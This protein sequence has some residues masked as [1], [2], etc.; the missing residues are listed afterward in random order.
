MS[1]LALLAIASLLS[2]FTVVDSRP[3]AAA[4]ISAEVAAFDRNTGEGN[5][6][7]TTELSK[8]LVVSFSKSGALSS[9]S[10]QGSAVASFGVLSTLG[11]ATASTVI[12]DPA[13]RPN[14]PNPASARGFGTAHF[15]DRITVHATSGDVLVRVSAV[16]HAQ[17]DSLGY[18]LD[19][20]CSPG[21]IGDFGNTEPFVL[22]HL[23]GF[24]IINQ[25]LGRGVCPRASD[26]SSFSLDL[27]LPVEVP[28]DFQM[29]LTTAAGAS[30]YFGQSPLDLEHNQTRISTS[31]VATNT[32][33]LL[34]QVLTPG[35]SY[36][37][38]SDAV[39]PTG[40]PVAAPASLT[41]VGA[42]L[43]ALAARG[44]RRWRS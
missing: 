16:L 24:G 35:G 32:G 40:V 26:L 39:Y 31:A 10:A 20:W 19:Y 12:D 41:L 4:S 38:D 34:I 30:P 11:T 22:L 21:K 28:I 9:E 42:G 33:F 13:D 3:V 18:D 27:T 44:R 37:T 29:T 5:F 7:S 6:D 15:E 25:T 23:E 43:V 14:D 2:L 1:H 36:S 17:V 8:P